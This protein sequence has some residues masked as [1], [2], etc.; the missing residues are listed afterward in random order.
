MARVLGWGVTGCDPA[1]MGL[2]PILAIP[3]A[4]AMAG[5][6]IKDMDLIEVNEAYASQFLAVKKELNLDPERTN[7]NGGAIAIGHPL[8]ASGNRLVLTLASELQL[9]KARYG[10]A[11]LCI[12]GGQGIALVLESVL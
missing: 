5:L 1:Y 2:G 9:R 4:L 7:V 8:G 12:G 3:K 6:T 10:I 11:S